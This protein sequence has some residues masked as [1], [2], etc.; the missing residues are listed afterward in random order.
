VRRILALDVGE[1]RIGVAISDP[2]QTLARSFLVLERKNDEEAIGRLAA[3]AREQDVER[4]VVGDPL[5]L[6]GD[7]GMQAERVR[8]FARDLEQMVEV[9]VELWDERFSSVDAERILRGQGV[10]GRRRRQRVDATAAAVILQSYLDA[11][12]WAQGRKEEEP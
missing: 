3:L 11:K 6:R 12:A 2:T 10:R 1:R 7:V 9:P 5:S 4:V 8:R